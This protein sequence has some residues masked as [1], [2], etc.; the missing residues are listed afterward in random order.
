MKRVGPELKMPEMKAPQFLSDLYWDLRDRRLLPLVG[1][2]LVAI[3]AVP[4]LLSRSGEEEAGPRR[5][6]AIGAGAAAV[7]ARSSNLIA[8]QAKPGLRDYHKRLGHRSPTDPFEQRFTA[9]Q[10]AD[11]KLQRDEGSSTTTTTTTTESADGK[12]TTTTTTDTTSGSGGGAPTGD[13]RVYTFGAD[14]Q[15]TRTEAK[16][17]GGKETSKQVKHEVLP[18]APLPSEKTQLVAYMGIAPQTRN[19]LFLV[20]DAVTGVFGESTCLS[21]AETCQLLEV[22]TGFPVTLVFGSG[23]VR[24]KL[25]VLEVKPVSTGKYKQGAR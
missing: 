12:S 10:L 21:G 24:Y 6:V 11:T 17:D 3:F 25:K 5:P 1:L 15:I 9:P 16:K 22:E 20:S 7:G 18:P 8:V 4:F 14:I 13:L 2:V 23:K 19:P